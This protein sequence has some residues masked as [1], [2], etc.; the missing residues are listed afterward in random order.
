MVAGTASCTAVQGGLLAGLATGAPPARSG[1]CQASSGLSGTGAVALFLT[2]RLTS[3]LAAGTLLGLLGS[4]VRLSPGARAVLLVAA[5]LAVIGFGLRAFA[6]APARRGAGPEPAAPARGSAGPGA[7]A[8]GP[9]ESSPAPP[10]SAGRAGV[11]PGAGRAVLLGAATVLLPCGVTLSAET[12]AVSSGSALGGAAVM[13]GFAAGTA[14]A[15]A[16]LGLALRRAASTRLAALA[17]VLALAAGVWTVTSGLRLGGWLP[18]P[19]APAAAA[20][21][22]PR[23]VLAGGVQRIDLWATDRGYRPG[24]V[25]ARAGVPVELVFRVAGDPGCARTLTVEGRDVPL[26]AVVRLGPRPAGTLR[27]SCSM[28]MYAGFVVFS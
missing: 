13:A 26:P 19:A 1:C 18:G 20:D 24:I 5:G 12:V 23:P 14:P 16:L 28:G 6:R 22:A 4:A 3:H 27:Y 21:T 15:F 17:G 7:A 8:R 25:A 11:P 9:S 2:G 10:G